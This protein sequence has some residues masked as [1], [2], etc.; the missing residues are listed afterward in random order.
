MKQKKRN[1][2]ELCN[3]NGLKVCNLYKEQQT[4]GNLWQIMLHSILLYAI[5]IKMMQKQ[6][7]EYDFA[8]LLRNMQYSFIKLN[9]KSMQWWRIKSNIECNLNHKEDVGALSL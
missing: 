2:Q 7:N 4:V 9:P 1:E 5:Y 3:M 8:F 6:D